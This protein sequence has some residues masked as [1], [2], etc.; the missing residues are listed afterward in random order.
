MTGQLVNGLASGVVHIQIKLAIAIGAEINLIA[1][2]HWINIINPPWRLW[3][4]FDG[5]RVAIKQPDNRIQTATITLPLQE[6]WRSRVI[7]DFPA[8]RRES[9]TRG[10]RDF[11]PGFDTTTHRNRE[12]V[13]IAVIRRHARR[14]K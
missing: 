9:R 12:Q 11:Q 7:G 14:S 8:I 2:P 4:T 10:I 3:N 1:N 6:S 5:L 13:A